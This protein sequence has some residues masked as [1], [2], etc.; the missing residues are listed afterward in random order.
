MF[1]KG[2]RFSIRMYAVVVSGEPFW[3]FMSSNFFVV[4]L[5]GSDHSKTTEK[6]SIIT[7]VHY[8]TEV[9]DN[10]YTQATLI[11]HLSRL[12]LLSVWVNETLPAIGKGLH[13]F[14]SKERMQ[15]PETNKR[16]EM[17]GCDILLDNDMTPW[18]LECN[19]CA[20]VMKFLKNHTAAFEELAYILLYSRYV[21]HKVP[22]L[23]IWEA[24][25]TIPGY[26]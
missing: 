17:F 11:D 20:G 26:V 14:L 3:G 5:A 2:K 12:G 6:S 25:K 15:S 19:R 8:N 22:H 13:G 10:G 7:N 4:L 16:F 23:H 24:F 1:L 18:L 21:G 9:A